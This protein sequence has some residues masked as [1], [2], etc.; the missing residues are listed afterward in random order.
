MDEPSIFAFLQAINVN[1]KQHSYNGDWLNIRCPFAPWYHAKGTDNSPSFGIKIDADKKS[2]CKCFSCNTKGSLAVIAA[3]LGRLRGKDY[4]EHQHW[5]EMT[6][7][8]SK[9]GRPLRDWDEAI[10][11]ALTPAA[12]APIP[13]QDALQEYP[14]A[15]GLPYLRKRGFNWLDV[16]KLDLR[17]DPYQKRVLFP[18][19]DE[20]GLFRGFS[21]RSIL[22]EATYDKR[23]PKIRDYF[24]LP[25]REL[26]LFHRDFPRTI[27]ENHGFFGRQ[28]FVEG[29][30][31]FGAAYQT[32]FINAN[33]TLGT[34]CTPQ[35]IKI[36]IE[37][38]QPAYFLF[39]N[40]KAGEDAVLGNLNEETG[41]IDESN[42]WAP[43]LYNDIPVWIGQWGDTPY[44]K[45]PRD[46]SPETIIS[47]IENAKL[48]TKSYSRV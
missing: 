25:K 17:Y 4:S 28:L 7:L 21:G 1:A 15:V 16:L 34:A 43:Q 20:D 46:V 23:N 48:Y 42:A 47:A 11:E 41:E 33:A 13:D 9:L 26:L 35:K 30:F 45:D 36:I 32:G 12:T 18:I 44:G 38:R 3:K 37:R 10:D 27:K 22:P 39:D 19:Y 8:Q 6:E 29:L 31:G 2:V 24:G 14:H 40:D 5:A